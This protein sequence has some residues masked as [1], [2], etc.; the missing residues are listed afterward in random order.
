MK[1][2]KTALFSTDEC[3]G[4]QINGMM[5]CTNINCKWHGISACA[6][7]SII[8][9]GRNSLGYKIGAEGLIENDRILPS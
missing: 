4:I 3:W 6:G 5:H 9:T 1:S 8:K 7:I 2:I